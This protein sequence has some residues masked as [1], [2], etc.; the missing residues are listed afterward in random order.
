MVR[1]RYGH[2]VCERP[3]GCRKR[4]FSGSYPNAYLSEGLANDRPNAALVPRTLAML[5]VPN[6]PG[7]ANTADAQRVPG[8]GASIPWNE[9]S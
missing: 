3:E 4:R 9:S 2:T 8:R 1:D 7:P 5:S 6:H